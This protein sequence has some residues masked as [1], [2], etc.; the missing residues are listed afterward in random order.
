[1]KRGSLVLGL[2]LALGALSGAS[3]ADPNNIA[4]NSL[5]LDRP[6]DIAFACFGGMR[7]TSDPAMP[8]VNSAQPTTSCDVRSAEPTATG[9]APEPRPAGQEDVGTSILGPANWYGFILQSASGTVAISRFSPKPASQFTGADIAVLDADVLTPGKNAISI[10]EEPIAIATDRTGCYEIT[11]NAGSCD[12]SVLDIDSALDGDPVTAVKVDRLPVKNKNGDTIYARPAAMVAEPSSAADVIGNVCTAA[13]TGLAYIAYPGCN[14]VFAVD[15]SDGLSAT[16]VAAIT[17]D[18]AGTPTLM[19][20]PS[21]VTCPVECPGAAG[22]VPPPTA[23]LTGGRP[24]TL[25]YRL[26][27]RTGVNTRRLAIG[28]DNSRSIAIVELGV[29]SRPLSLSQ[30]ALEDKT[31]TAQNPKGTLGVTQIALSPQIGTG[32][33]FV[34]DSSIDD[35]TAP[36]GQAQYV[37]A[38]A[39]DHTVRVADVL[40]VNRPQ[41][42]TECDT[43]IDNRILQKRADLNRSVPALQCLPVGDPSLP[44]RSGAR[45]PGIELPGDIVPTSVAFF[46]RPLTLD[47]TTNTRIQPGTAPSNLY[48]H[49]AIITASNGAGFVVNVDDDNNDPGTDTFEPDHPQLTAP[50][51]IIPHQLRDSVSN[52]DATATEVVPATTTAAATTRPSC[53]ALGTTLSGGPRSTTPPVPDLTAGTVIASKAGELPTLRQFR[54]TATDAPDPGIAVSELEFPNDPLSRNLV[55]PDLRSLPADENWSLTWEGPLSLDNINI[56]VDGPPIREGQLFSDSTV[57][58]RIDDR[59]QPFCSVGVQPFDIV[60]LRGCNP[61]N[62]GLDCPSSYKCYVHANSSVKIGGAALGACMLSS[63]ADRL[64]TACRDFL[65]SQRRYTVKFAHSGEL[66]LMPRMH[67]LR[68]TPLDGCSSDAQCTTLADYA[69]QNTIDVVDLAKPDAHDPH[70]WACRADDTRAPLN[71]DPARNKRCI[72][73]CRFHSN[74]L[75]DKNADGLDRDTDCDAGSI[76]QGAS[77]AVAATGTPAVAGVCMEGILPPQAC[78]NGPQRYEVRAGEAFTVIGDHS[79]YIHPLI[80][81]AVNPLDPV[82]GHGGQCILDPTASALQ[83]GRIPL[84]L[85]ACDPAA[86]PLTGILPN[87]T[88]APNP[89]TTTATQTDNK[90]VYVMDSCTSDPT[91]PTEVEDRANTPAIR[92]RNRSLTLT[93]VDP[94]YPG[95]AKCALDRQGIAGIDPAERIPL[96]FP[97]YRLSF[98]VTSGYTPLTLS[99][100]STLFNPAFPVKVVAG[101]TGSIWVL[102]DGDFLSMSLGLSSTLG[103]VYRVESVNLGVVNLL[104]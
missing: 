59:T 10:G 32:G 28:A 44:R 24:V 39:T 83:I 20:D 42:R 85:P 75:G 45:G 87:G 73:T 19:A 76:C 96:V 68:T 78:V 38:V 41:G 61:A 94:T 2:G 13:P 3:C 48:G 16:I 26:D 67:E 4:P 100:N 21:G 14:K 70:T 91:K 9:T 23:P 1:M 53:L 97:G 12:V 82:T 104:Q 84:T 18:A 99:T 80:E 90:P 6:V 81:G 34:A 55:F 71:A 60:Q 7:I 29:D 15:M 89:C 11:A 72:Q 51:L 49:F 31:I 77:P 22:K 8:L 86:D 103:A 64:A 35:T 66:Q 36:G 5:N 37:Y 27:P 46:Q 33:T 43:Q 62:S 47:L 54:C 30:V 56:A 92:F 65:I 17:Y 88:Y 102:D 58:G 52:R 25:A 74:V 98:H 57:A 50:T 95:D 101:P 69:A 93:L 63:E 40:G 79:G